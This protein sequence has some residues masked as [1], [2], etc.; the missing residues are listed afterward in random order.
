MHLGFAVIGRVQ[1]GIL[2]RRVGGVFDGVCGS[3]STTGD[4]SPGYGMMMVTGAQAKSGLSLFPVPSTVGNDVS[5]ES[6]TFQ[7]GSVAK[8]SLPLCDTTRAHL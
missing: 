2:G 7:K 4:G 8:S 1:R 3:S 5:N 6:V